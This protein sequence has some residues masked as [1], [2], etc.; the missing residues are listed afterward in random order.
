MKVLWRLH[1][2]AFR[3]IHDTFNVVVLSRNKVEIA[4]RLIFGDL[5]RE[6]YTRRHTH[7]RELLNKLITRNCHNPRFAPSKFV[8]GPCQEHYG[9][10]DEID[11]LY[12]RCQ[13]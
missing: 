7:I 5:R 2:D 3:S 1:F 12:V 13:L 11:E 6:I 9:G 10:E 4:T 8:N